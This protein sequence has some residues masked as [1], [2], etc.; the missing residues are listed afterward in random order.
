M[1]SQRENTFIKVHYCGEHSYRYMDMYISCTVHVGL[2][3]TSPFHRNTTQCTTA[4]TIVRY[5]QLL[6]SKSEAFTV[7]TFTIMLNELNTFHMGCLTMRFLSLSRA[8]AHTWTQPAPKYLS[9]DSCAYKPPGCHQTFWP[10][11]SIEWAIGY[12]FR[13][14]QST[15]V[16]LVSN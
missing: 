2:H 3:A 16:G 11:A 6:P 15:W 14:P 1:F 9:V 7:A 5:L 12:E 13:P 4:D 10:N 8:S